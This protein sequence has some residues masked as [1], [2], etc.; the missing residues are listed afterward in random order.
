MRRGR[1]REV[2]EEL[3]GGRRVDRREERRCK[4]AR[5]KRK[6]SRGERMDGIER[7]Q[8]KT[9]K[10]NRKREEREREKRKIMKQ[11][12]REGVQWK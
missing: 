10:G 4:E 8:E 12:Q 2:E 9:R 3:K 1:E 11:K 7:G 6:G 5:A